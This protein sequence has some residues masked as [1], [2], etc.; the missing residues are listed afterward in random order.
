MQL[1][2][3]TY[4]E[5]MKSPL[6]ENGYIMLS[7]GLI[8]QEAQSKA[9]VA[10]SN[11]LAYFSN[12]ENT[13]SHKTYDTAYATLE[14]DFTR[15]DGSMYFLPR[16]GSDFF[17]DTGLT[18]K[19]LVSEEPFELLVTIGDRPIDFKGL[20]INFGE[21]Y[22]IDF[23]V[24]TSGGYVYEV[25]GNTESKFIT[26]EV[27]ENTTSVKLVVHNLLHP[28][29]RVRVYSM[30]FGY[31]L[32][33]TNEEV[34]EST[35]ESYVSPIGADL[36][37][38]DFSVKIT[39]YDRYFNVDN[40]N[41][42]IHFFE[43]GQ[44][45]EL[46]YGYQHPDSEE[47]EWIKG[48]NLVCS[49][50][51]S[52]DTTA[53]INCQD[54]LRSMESEYYKGVYNASGVSYYELATK[55]FEDAGITDYYLDP[56]LKE[57][58]TTNPLPKVRHKECL[59]IIAN[60]CRC[61]LS[62]T[63]DGK[64]SIKSSYIPD[65]FASADTQ[66]EYSKVENILVEGDK[67]EYGTYATNYT[68]T[69]GGM[70]FLPREIDG[71]VLNTGYVSAEISDANGRFENNPVVTLTQDGVCMYYGVR[72]VF[73]QTLPSE[74]IIRTYNGDVPVNAYRIGADEI[75]KDSVILREFADFNV[76][77]IEFTK[78]AE[79][80]NRIVLN[81]FAFGD[82]TDFTM[83]RDDM[84]S[85]P[86]S[87]KQ[88]LVKEIIVPCYYYQ[89]GSEE[90][91]IISEEVT[92]A[93][94]D[95]ITFLTEEPS[96]NF[97]ATLDEGSSG[98]NIVDWGNY[99]VTVKFSVSGTHKLEVFGWRYK[100]VERYVVNQLNERGSTIKWE[101]PLMSDVTMATDLAEWLGDF[102]GGVIEY[103][104]DTRGNP[105]LDANDI[106]YQENDFIEKMKVNVYR[107]TLN[108]SQGFSGK[109][110]ARRIGG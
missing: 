95:V 56:H 77:K 55:V 44:P 47:I 78:T 101:N 58:F 14:E 48:S 73:G 23:D 12:P 102:Y 109:V 69:D 5:S 3:K 53:T 94:G 27:L 29:G 70:Y 54:V 22:P 71:N 9:V 50:W 15:V 24:V 31:G 60:A 10:E 8:N 86:K 20:T 104:Y 108:F 61:V 38:F 67:D 28:A 96:Y 93:E 63:R 1:V 19:N 11:E 52:D 85:S 72:L 13:F 49:S 6:R 82:I 81:Y 87:I 26:E 2:S 30:L 98:V 33:Y 76:M 18:S 88:E 25:R 57:L 99:F 100:I 16:E 74:F 59:Q 34:V 39:N 90:T 45:L 7:F 65:V 103:E 83:G 91:S 106:I 42:A 4:K 80:Y 64:I 107:Q 89:A 41:S 110:T 43:T 84:L 97:R 51:E 75:S 40:P 17:L 36:P 105:E 92:V 35:L 66:A 32:V 21:N 37:Q 62:Q 68:V 46:F 79:P